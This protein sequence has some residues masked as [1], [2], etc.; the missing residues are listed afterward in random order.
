[1]K[2]MLPLRELQ[3]ELWRETEQDCAVAAHQQLLASGRLACLQVAAGEASSSREG[4]HVR[5]GTPSW[6]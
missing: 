5:G 3:R 1:M 4:Q 6:R 2:H